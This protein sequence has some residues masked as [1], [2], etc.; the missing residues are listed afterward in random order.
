VQLLFEAVSVLVNF[1]GISDIIELSHLY[2]VNQLDMIDM[3]VAECAASGFVLVVKRRIKTKTSRILC[4]IAF[5]L[6]TVA[7]DELKLRK[8]ISSL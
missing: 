5:V 3:L 1:V 2:S 7:S 8:I 4:C 6:L